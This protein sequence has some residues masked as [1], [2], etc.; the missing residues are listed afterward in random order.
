MDKGKEITVDA[1]FSGCGGLDLG[2]EEVGFRVQWANE[3]DSKIWRTYRL[4]HKGA[5]LCERSVTE[6][7]GADVPDC[8]GMIGGPPCQSWS[9]A[10]SRRGIGDKRGRLFWNY[11]SLIC[12]KKPKFF[13]VE[14]VK[15][16][17]SKKNSAAFRGFLGAFSEAGGGYDVSWRLLDAADY[18]VPENRERV[19]IVGIR[20]DLGFRFRFPEPTT[21]R[22]RVTLRDAIGD[23]AS[24]KP[25]GAP[26]RACRGEWE[27]NWDVRNHEFMEGGFSPV[28]MSRNRV[29]KWDEPSFTI[30]AFGRAVPL[31]PGAPQMV[32]VG[33]DEMMF[34]PGQEKRY[35]RL[36]VRECAR[37][38][39]FPDWFRFLYDNISDGYKM[40]GNAVPPRLAKALAESLKEQ[41]KENGAI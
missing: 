39:T 25:V 29:R 34:V 20:K 35:R 9:V 24:K 14:N 16:I 31:H 19:I 17:L 41:L 30:P 27:W 37:I 10:G 1:F 13:L 36:T 38:Q 2:F 33:P 7:T 4:N 26:N 32:R 28:F 12:E 40:V 3:F 15:G 5:L 6:L 18:G 22:W 8:D 11:I 23:L 21:P